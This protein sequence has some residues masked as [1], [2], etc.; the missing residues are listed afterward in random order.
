M[1]TVVFYHE[2]LQKCMCYHKCGRK[3]IC[4]IVCYLPG[5]LRQLETNI[6]HP[7]Y[8][9]GRR[10]QNRFF[11][12]KELAVDRNLLDYLIL[13]IVFNKYE[14]LDIFSKTLNKQCCSKSFINLRCWLIG[15]G[16]WIWKNA[17]VL[18]WLLDIKWVYLLVTLEVSSYSSIP[19]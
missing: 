9:G 2:Q 18:L 12:G 15:T 10:G 1:H 17:Y 4:R 13:F 16:I 6:R 11:K 14:Q 3:R 8:N 19:Y 5:L 7:C